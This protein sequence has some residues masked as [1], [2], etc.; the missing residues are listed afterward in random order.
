MYDSDMEIKQGNIFE[1]KAE[2]LVNAVNCVGVMGKGIA[3]QFR[4][5]Y[6]EMFRNYVAL[7]TSGLVVPG[8]PYL[9]KNPVPPSVLN[10]PTKNNWR[11]PSCISYIEDGLDYFAANYEQMG[12]I[13]IAFPALGCGCGGLDWNVVKPLMIR[14]LDNLPID[15]EIYSPM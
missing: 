7:C 5:R 10:F 6:P 14:K 2:V 8:V 15:V 1:S 4:S 3:L 11:D 13:S 9:Y 12:I